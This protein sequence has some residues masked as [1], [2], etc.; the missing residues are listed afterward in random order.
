[1]IFDQHSLI[2]QSP[3]KM[4]TALIIRYTK[5]SLC[6]HMW[7][8]VHVRLCVHVCSHL[9]PSSKSICFTINLIAV[10]LVWV[11]LQY[12]MIVWHHLKDC[13]LKLFWMLGQCSISWNSK[14][15]YKRKIYMV[16]MCVYYSVFSNV[17]RFMCYYWICK[18]D[19]FMQ[20][21]YILLL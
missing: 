3:L 5:L 15:T 8:C 19:Y 11:S 20:H 1:L 2:K 13:S 7:L 18:S 9:L 10:L 12:V 16:Y 6:V 4:L 21:Y 17:D 14:I